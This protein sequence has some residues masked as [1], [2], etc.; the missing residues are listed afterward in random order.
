MKKFEIHITASELIHDICKKIQ[1]KTIIV[2]LLKPD[3]SV[4]STEHMTS[5]VVSS[6]SYK[7]CKE[8]VDSIVDCFKKQNVDVF[9][10][11]IECPFYSEYVDQAIYIEAHNKVNIKNLVDI[12]FPLSKTQHK[13]E[14]IL[15]T[16]RLYHTRSLNA[17]SPL[18]KM[19]KFIEFRDTHRNFQEIEL[20]LFD[21]FVGQDY[22]WF[23]LYKN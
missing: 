12:N 22:E 5:H 6:T 19:D 10:V 7:D 15:S 4:L 20:C 14:N 18:S 9:R 8:W 2:D 1:I 16:D 11:K 21:S 23:S 3:L 17:Y 13:P